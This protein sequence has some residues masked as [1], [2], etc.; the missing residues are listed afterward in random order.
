[1]F[2]ARPIPGRPTTLP[3]YGRIPPRQNVKA[4]PYSD[5]VIVTLNF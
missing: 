4:G 3:V 5:V 2:R 1:V